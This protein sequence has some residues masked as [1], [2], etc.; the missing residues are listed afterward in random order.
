MKYDQTT[1][2]WMILCRR[3]AVRLE[4]EFGTVSTYIVNHLV[5]QHLEFNNASAAPTDSSLKSPSAPIH[6]QICEGI[7]QISQII[8]FVGVLFF[9]LKRLSVLLLVMNTE[10]NNH[11]LAL[12]CMELFRTL[13]EKCGVSSSF[14]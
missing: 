8:P 6:T 11:L 3:N 13:L 7:I 1:L 10:D 4:W 5:V 12:N 2:S 9:L 14:N